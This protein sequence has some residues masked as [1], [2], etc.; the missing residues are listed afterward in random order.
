MGG[1]AQS[2]SRCRPRD[3]R[4]RGLAGAGGAD[5][6]SPPA[7]PE[8]PGCASGCLSRKDA[9]AHPTLAASGGEA[10]S[11]GRRC[12]H[13]EGPPVP[14]V[15]PRGPEP[16]ASPCEP[17]MRGAHSPG[18]GRTRTCGVPRVSRSLSRLG[19]ARACDSF[20]MRSRGAARGAEPAPQPGGV[21]EAPR[22]TARRPWQWP[23]RRRDADPPLP[24]RAEVRNVMG[25]AFPTRE[26][27]Y[28]AGC[29]RLPFYLL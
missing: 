17:A 21:P 13:E 24:E 19:A 23:E 11:R 12:R 20:R 29:Y 1:A 14:L 10:G 18:A 3:P 9:P 7:T 4:T 26:L 16:S 27:V 6:R 25:A 8:A 5:A 22:G 28:L 15:P 2:R